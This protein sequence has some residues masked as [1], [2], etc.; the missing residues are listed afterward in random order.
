MTYLQS[1]LTVFEPFHLLFQENISWK[2]ENP[3]FHQTSL[4]IKDAQVKVKT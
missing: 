2:T 4:L 3:A 1:G